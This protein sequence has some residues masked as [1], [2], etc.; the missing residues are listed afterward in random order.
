MLP[1]FLPWSLAPT[2]ELK[3]A[4]PESMQAWRKRRREALLLLGF[5]TQLHTSWYEPRST[6]PIHHKVDRWAFFD[7]FLRIATLWYYLDS[8][9]W[10]FMCFH[11]C[12]CRSQDQGSI[13]ESFGATKELSWII[14]GHWQYHIGPPP[15]LLWCWLLNLRMVN[16]LWARSPISFKHSMPSWCPLLDLH[17]TTHHSNTGVWLR[18]VTK[19]TPPT[20]CWPYVVT[21]VHWTPT[22]EWYMAR[23][24]FKNGHEKDMQYDEI[25][26]C[27]QHIDNILCSIVNITI[28]RAYVIP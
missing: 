7:C 22:F 27:A 2:L 25:G 8:Q 1:I 18:Q 13:P 24:G 19:F 9:G 15:P 21:L 23:L 4:P 14:E 5:H 6:S 28:G 3:E 12:I 26:L 16:T 11:K 17:L 20:L 10:H